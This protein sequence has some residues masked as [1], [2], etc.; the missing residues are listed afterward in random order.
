MARAKSCGM[1][2]IPI[3]KTKIR[4]RDRS[5]SRN[6]KIEMKEA[7]LAV[8]E[9]SGRIDHLDRFVRGMKNN[10]SFYQLRHL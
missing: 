4:S 1:I 6:F 8:T 2:F 9:L 10:S 3:C 5:F 7:L